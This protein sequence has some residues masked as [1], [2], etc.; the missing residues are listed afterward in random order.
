MSFS[1]AQ[2]VARYLELREELN[3][4]ENKFKLACIPHKDKMNQ[5]ETIVG[6]MLTE[7][8]KDNMPTEA[9][10]AYKKEIFTVTATNLPEF[11]DYA[12]DVDPKMLKI[13]P[14]TTGVKAFIDK[15]V[16]E[17]SK[18]VENERV[19]V[20]IPGI[21]TDKIIKVIFRKV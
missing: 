10:T 9:G 18:L 4:M 15:K 2:I 12:C 11:V 5:L 1:D 7:R 17:N 13:E 19:P 8:K 3:Q 21:K 14:S 6:V 16:K 20:I